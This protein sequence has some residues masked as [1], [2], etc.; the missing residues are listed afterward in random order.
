MPGTVSKGQIE[1]AVCETVNQFLRERI[2]RGAT[3]MSATLHR[4]LMM[5]HLRGALTRIEENL[6]RS[7]DHAG[8]T[9]S[10]IREMRARLVGAS[11][12][13]LLKSLASACGRQPETMLHDLDVDT[14]DEVFIFRLAAE[15][16]RRKRLA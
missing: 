1:A 5:V 14:G 9:R 3:S 6:I 2:G 15:D 16:V 11:R 10:L 7:D 13:E 4:D 8:G 12:Q